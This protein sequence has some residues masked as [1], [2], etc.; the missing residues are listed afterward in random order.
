MMDFVSEHSTEDASFKVDC[1]HLPRYNFVAVLDTKV[2]VL[3]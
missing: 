1:S 2:A 3:V